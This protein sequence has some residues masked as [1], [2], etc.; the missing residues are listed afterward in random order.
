MTIICYRDGVLASD[1]L[2]VYNG[3]R[4]GSLAKIF[5]ASDG[6][7]AGN[8]GGGQL[9]DAFR[10]WFLAGA[11]QATRPTPQSNDEFAALVIKPSGEV[12]DVGERCILTRLE[13][14]FYAIGSGAPIAIG[15]MEMGATAEQAVAAA[16]KWQTSCGG[17]IQVLR[18][19]SPMVAHLDHLK[20][21]VRHSPKFPWRAW[22]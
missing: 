18:L 14:P 20:T 19:D 13:A 2:F 5:R 21:M 22:P 16:I 7:I 9:V 12:Y 3:R 1:S 10:E 8:A 11:D 17:E 15:A 4:H 6:S